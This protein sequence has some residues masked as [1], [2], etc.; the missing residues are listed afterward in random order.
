MKYL[1]AWLSVCL[2]AVLIFSGVAISPTAAWADNQPPE[3]DSFS[4]VSPIAGPGVFSLGSYGYCLDFDDHGKTLT[5]CAPTAGDDEYSVQTYLTQ[6]AMN[7]LVD[8]LVSE[9][10]GALCS[11]FYGPSLLQQGVFVLLGLGCH[12]AGIDD[13]EHMTFDKTLPNNEHDLDGYSVAGWYLLPNDQDVAFQQAMLIKFNLLQGGAGSNDGYEAAVYALN[14]AAG[15]TP[16]PPSSL[17]V[18]DQGLWP[19]QAAHDILIQ[20]WMSALAA[21]GAPYVY[22]LN[23]NNT[24]GQDDITLPMALTSLTRHYGG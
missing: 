17:T 21:S 13:Y 4:D 24:T 8:P 15:L 10:G 11:G 2:S 5:L 20:P 6:D 23:V 19:P 7:T 1:K 9:A 3:T 14:V 22:D 18:L 16:A 12:N